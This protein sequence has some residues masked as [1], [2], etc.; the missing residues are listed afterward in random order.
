MFLCGCNESLKIVINLSGNTLQA[1]EGL[2]EVDS[3]ST[4]KTS[5]KKSHIL[6]MNANFWKYF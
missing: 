6:G 3:V 5:L 4:T 2:T 1:S